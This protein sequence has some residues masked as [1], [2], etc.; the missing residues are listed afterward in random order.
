MKLHIPDIVWAI[1]NFFIL[2]AV[3]NKFLYKPLLGMLEKRKEEIIRNLENAKAAE[4]EAMKLKEDYSKTIELSR[5]EAQ[6]ILDKA[7]R[8]G[9][10]TK[11]KIIEQAKTEAGKIAVKA[12][13]TIRLEKEEALTQLRFEVSSLV[14]E[15]AG[16]ILE[17]TITKEDQEK[18]IR[19]IIQEVGDAS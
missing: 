3:L 6:E 7:A 11:D 16:R 13:N 9:E 5:H 19:N 4:A 1:I 17:R 18:M 14:V 15:A 10:E 2:V 12:Q 8:L